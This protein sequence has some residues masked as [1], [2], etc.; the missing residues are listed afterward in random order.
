MAKMEGKKVQISEKALMENEL[1]LRFWPTARSMC[2]GIVDLPYKSQIARNHKEEN[3]A[4]LT[5]TMRFSLNKDELQVL[6][7]SDSVDVHF[8]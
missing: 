4:M 3:K 8:S 5:D 2:Q 7:E 1:D 6:L